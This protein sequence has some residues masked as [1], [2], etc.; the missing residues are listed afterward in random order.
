MNG[1]FTGRLRDV[2]IRYRFCLEKLFVVLF[3][4]TNDLTEFN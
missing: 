1:A 3:S 2:F 4:S